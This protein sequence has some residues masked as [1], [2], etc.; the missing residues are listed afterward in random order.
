MIKKMVDKAATSS[1]SEQVDGNKSA[2]DAGCTPTGTNDTEN[3]PLKPVMMN[4]VGPQYSGGKH[5]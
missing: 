1:K 4:A 5:S 3:E 2:P